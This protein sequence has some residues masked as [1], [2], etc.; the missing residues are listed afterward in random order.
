MS[1]LITHR[2]NSCLVFAEGRCPHQLIMERVYIVPQLIASEKLREFQ[3]KCLDCSYYARLRYYPL[4]LEI[5][6]LKT[7]VDVE[8]QVRV[9]TVREKIC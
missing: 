1:I 7:G 5:D 3:R 4:G 8:K 9:S 6:D 2:I